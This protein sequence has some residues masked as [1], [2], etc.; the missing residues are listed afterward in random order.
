M[1]F[2]QAAIELAEKGFHVFPL[3]P[4]SKVPTNFMDDFP[5]RATRD[6]KQLYR[7]WH[8]PLLEIAQPYNIGISTS[9][10]GDGNDALLVVDVDN[11]G[12]KK[13]DDE[14]FR[15]ELEGKEF[16]ETFEQ[17]TPSGGKHLIYRVREAVRQ[18]TDVLAKGLDIRSSGGYVAGTGSCFGGGTYTCIARDLAY[19]PGWLISAC[20]RKPEHGPLSGE[21]IA[22]IS[23]DTSRQRAIEYLSKFAPE[24][25]KGQGGDATAYQ[26]AARVKDFGVP[27]ADCLELMLEHWFSGSGWSPEKL[28]AKVAHA[29]KYGINPVGAASPQADFDEIPVDEPP[30]AT[31]LSP[32]E[33]LNQEFAFVLAGGNSHILWETLD[34]RGLYRLEHLAIPAFHQKLAAKKMQVGERTKPITEVWMQHPARRS[35]DGMCFMPELEAP[36]RFYNLWRGFAVKPL[37]ENE[38]PTPEAAKSLSLFLEHCLQNV[39]GGDKSLHDWLMGYFAHMIQKPWEKP[40]VALV[41]KGLKGVGKNAL[42][43]RVGHLLGSH[44]LLASNRRYLVGNFNGHLENLLL[45]TLDEAF[46]SGDKQAEGVLKDLI[47]GNT[48]VVEHKGKESYSVENCTRVCIIGN[49]GWL[50]PASQDERRFAVFNV[51]NGRRQDRA[52]FRTM[53]EGMERGGY[54]VLLRYLL[55]FDLSKTEVNQA[56]QTQGLLDQKIASLEPFEQWWHEC[57]SEG[58]LVDSEFGSEWPT[59]VPKSRFRELYSRY[60]RSRSIRTRVPSS[61][62]FGVKF[63]Q[64]FPSANRKAK[65][66]DGTEILNVYRF[67]DLVQARADWSAYIGHDVVWE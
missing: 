22:G 27:A 43:D 50:V 11:K 28:K 8:D 38:H 19:A 12:D 33:E 66:R 64:L 39:C 17:R 46:W 48:H 4:G 54:S 14:L 29:Y 35:F 2:Y 5:S 16:P 26:V 25:V 55:D 62:E 60:H 61:V 49:E 30:S 6:P 52:F 36:P 20:G 3:A 10:F 32:V 63:S 24:S 56:P 65:R 37:P 23:P 9:A 1:S 58:R 57:L 53:R 47:T 42:I 31:T 45:F 15:L 51:G 34:H 21:T 41:F 59:E 7:W 18:G 67:A 44:Y 40:L 13:G